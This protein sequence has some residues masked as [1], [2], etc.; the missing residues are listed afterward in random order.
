MLLLASCL[1]S[2]AAMSIA[3]DTATKA[4]LVQMG[5]AREVKVARAPPPATLH[6][7]E[8][9][10]A[11]QEMGFVSEV[12]TRPPSARKELMASIL[13]DDVAYKPTKKLAK[14]DNVVI[15]AAFPDLGGSTDSIL[16][17]KRRSAPSQR[18]KSASFA[19]NEARG[20]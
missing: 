12:R 19:R 17:A 7:Q 9:E 13:R 20:A 14:P 8:E 11:W 5:L 4:A 15:K 18:S 16:R 6:L 2:A 10:V 1:C 3:S